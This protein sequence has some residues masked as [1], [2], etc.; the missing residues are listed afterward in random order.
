MR[1]LFLMLCSSPPNFQNCLPLN[2]LLADKFMVKNLKLLTLP[3]H[4]LEIEVTEV[5]V[6]GKGMT[7]SFYCKPFN[8]SMST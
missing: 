2:D 4:L 7:I 1:S 6:V 8:K 3:F 5:S